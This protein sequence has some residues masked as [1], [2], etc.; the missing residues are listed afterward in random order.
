MNNLRL[1]IS[2]PN[3]NNLVAVGPDTFGFVAKFFDSNNAPLNSPYI[4]NVVSMIVNSTNPA[5]IPLNVP[6]VDGNY[7]LQ[8]V[9]VRLYANADSDCCFKEMNFTRT[10][11]FSGPTVSTDAVIM[12]SLTNPGRIYRYEPATQVLIQLFVTPWTVCPDVA[13]TANKLWLYNFVEIEGVL[14]D[15]L[16]EYNITLN[17][18]TYTFSKAYP[19]SPS[20]IGAGLCAASDTRL[21]ICN[22]KVT[23]LNL[24]GSVATTTHRFDLPDGY[25]CTGDLIYDGST[26]LFIISYNDPEADARIGV[27]DITG[28]LLRSALAPVGNIFG[29]YQFSGSTYLISA[30][31]QVYSLNLST[32]ASTAVNTIPGIS[33]A[34]ASQI[35]SKI[36]IPS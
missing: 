35:P 36:S 28:T 1:T 7:T 23:E 19:M 30:T 10:N 2:L 29:I 12:N 11:T 8:D 22:D 16:L 21:F 15:Y 33:I 26:N 5:S 4:Q 31:G 18:F 9:K 32:L 27:F 20:I 3:F 25:V 6:V 24:S 14:Q 34:G 13:H 17:P